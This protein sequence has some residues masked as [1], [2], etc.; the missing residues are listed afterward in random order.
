MVAP[1]LEIRS[2]GLRPSPGVSGDVGPDCLAQQRRWRWTL[3][4]R[5]DAE[6]RWVCLPAASGE[7]TYLAMEHGHFS[8]V[9]HL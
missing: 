9:N 6:G 2:W 5:G 4:R 3:R 1:C 7:H 8:R